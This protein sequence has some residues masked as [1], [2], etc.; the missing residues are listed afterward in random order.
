MQPAYTRQDFDHS[1][2]LVFFETTRACDLMCVHCRADA[3]RDCDPNELST[4]AAQRLIDELARFPRKPLL[5]FTG[6]DPM[7]RRDIFQLVRHARSAGLTIAMTPSA[8]PLVTT[9]AIHRLKDAGLHRLAV[10]LDGASAQSHDEFRQVAGSYQRTLEII[11][12]AADCGLPMQINTTLARHNL[13]ELEA[14]IPL[15]AT[16]P[17]EL[18]SV[19]FL[20]PVGRGQ[21]DQRLSA[22]ESEAVFEKLRTLSKQVPFAI[23]TTEAP[24]YRRYLIQNAGERRGKAM[25]TSM[26]GTNDGKGVMFISHTGEIC[27]SGFLPIA[28]GQ[29]PIDSPVRVYQ[30]SQLFQLLRDGD[31]L[32]GKCGRCEFRNLCG[33]SRARSF[34]VSGDPLAEEPDCLYIPQRAQKAVEQSA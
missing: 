31:R 15:L 27:P 25:P 7:K 33:G 3:Q 11:R 10:S 2:L 6:G 30:Q 24:H 26:V 16:L 4:A 18:W 5:V 32:G 28:C 22:A 23:K 1:P 13:H 12:D 8:T 14:F 17:I 34:A 20:I 19:F 21:M 29:F 9:E